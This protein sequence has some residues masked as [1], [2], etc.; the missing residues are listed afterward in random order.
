MSSG[1]RIALTRDGSCYR[2]RPIR[3]D[4]ADRERAFIAQLS[5]E[6]R[7]MRLMYSLRDPTEAF[8]ERLV[9]VDYHTSMAFVA[10][11]GERTHERIIGVA[12]YAMDGAAQA[13]FAV[14]VMDDWQARGVGMTLSGLLFEY[15]QAQGVRNVH[16]TMLA[17]NHHMIELAHGLGMLTQRQAEDPG[18]ITAARAL[19]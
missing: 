1:E 3:A 10:V 7:Y 16:A 4:D 5:P 15:A 14:A 6:S 17:A 8:V 13:E 18:L 19:P 2:I 9:H 12:R 11:I